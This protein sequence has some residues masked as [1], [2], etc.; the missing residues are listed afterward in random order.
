MPD[1]MERST[2]SIE[3]LQLGMRG[4]WFTALPLAAELQ[5]VLS[6]RLAVVITAWASLSIA[7]G[8]ANAGGKRTDWRVW[9]LTLADV[10][11]AILAVIL[12]GM[13]TSPLWWCTLIGSVHLMLEGRNRQARLWIGIQAAILGVVSISIQPIGFRALIPFG[14]HLA[15]LFISAGGLEVVCRR[16]RREAE[17]MML[18]Q[19][20]LSRERQVLRMISFQGADLDDLLD[21]GRLGDLVLDLC[22][23]AL[24]FPDK[25]SGLLISALFSPGEAGYSIMAARRLTVADRRKSLSA[26]DGLI[27]TTHQTLEP[28]YCNNLQDDPALSSLDGL[29]GCNSALALPIH[30]DEMVYGSLLFVHPRPDYFNE[31]RKQLLQFVAQQAAIVM[32]NAY[33]YREMKQEKDRLVEVQEETRRKLARDLHDGPT[34]TMAAIAMRVNFAKRMIDTSQDKLKQELGRIEEMARA[35]TKEIRHMLFTLR[36]LILESQ[37]LGAALIQLADKIEVTHGQAVQV[38]TDEDAGLGLPAET[39]VGMFYIA[40][41][42]ITNACK[43]AASEQIKVRLL[44]QSHGVVLIVEDDGVGFSVGAVDERYEQRGSLGF[45]NMRERAEVIGGTLQVESDLGRGTRVTLLVP[46]S[47]R[48]ENEPEHVL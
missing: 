3:I 32:K 17:Q 27:Y 33:L 35:T 37:G 40:E 10:L 42:A 23:Q 31:A 5:G 1:R 18:E 47:E 34:Q 16:I 28:A 15:V 12:S 38:H 48:D 7:M 25:E 26:E 36:P 14:L 44:Q 21:E 41:E 8:V 13:L 30:L 20:R 22:M 46:F 4:L 43:H 24:S 29:A 45:V 39:Q 2:R 6:I 9:A 11:F 19:Q